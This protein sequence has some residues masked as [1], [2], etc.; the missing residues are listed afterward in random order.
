MDCRGVTT[1]FSQRANL[2]RKSFP[3]RTFHRKQLPV[4]VDLPGLSQNA[5]ANSLAKRASRTLDAIYHSRNSN[6]WWSSSGWTGGYGPE[7]MIYPPSNE[8]HLAKLARPTGG[9]P[10]GGRNCSFQCESA[11]GTSNLEV[12]LEVAAETSFES[13]PAMAIWLT[14]SAAGRLDSPACGQCV[15]HAISHHY[16]TCSSQ[17]AEHCYY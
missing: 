2:W 11:V 14:V 12:L 8:A 6:G 16:V 5:P 10:V 15:L 1:T 9:W 3:N 4:L 13:A 7:V 17:K